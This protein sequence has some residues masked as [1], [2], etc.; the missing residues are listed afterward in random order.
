MPWL[1]KLDDIAVSYDEVQMAQ[2]IDLDEISE[3]LSQPG[4]GPTDA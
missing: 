3:M 4:G 2:E 1:E